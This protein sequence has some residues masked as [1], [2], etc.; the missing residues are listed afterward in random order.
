MNDYIYIY[1]SFYLLPFCFS[2]VSTS[3]NTGVCICVSDCC[4]FFF[5]EVMYFVFRCTTTMMMLFLSFSFY[6]FCTCIL[7]KTAHTYTVMIKLIPLSDFLFSFRHFV[8]C[9]RFFFF[10]MYVYSTTLSPSEQ[11]NFITRINNLFL[12]FLQW[13]INI[14]L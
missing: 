4:F 1:M 13:S 6:S 3:V 7:W 2:N 14:S 11:N 9:T 10:S 8:Y 12:F 5:F